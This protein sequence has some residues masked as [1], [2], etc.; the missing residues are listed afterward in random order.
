MANAHFKID[1]QVVEVLGSRV[2]QLSQMLKLHV[3]RGGVK[4]AERLS[5]HVADG[6]PGEDLLELD[7]LEQRGLL[8]AI[9]REAASSRSLPDDLAKL[10]TA[11][12]EALAAR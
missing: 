12:R 6:E 5:R 2:E 4:L 8:E 11:L 9:D 1:G 7:E 3:W 10:R